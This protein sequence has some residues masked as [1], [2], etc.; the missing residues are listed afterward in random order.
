MH[1][2]GTVGVPGVSGCNHSNR[3][4]NAHPVQSWIILLTLGNIL[5]VIT[6]LAAVNIMHRAL[7]YFI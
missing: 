2:M 1:A 5:G 7:F 3:G 4:C 6:D